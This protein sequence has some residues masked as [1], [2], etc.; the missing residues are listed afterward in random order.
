MKSTISVLKV[1]VFA[2]MLVGFACS[3]EQLDNLAVEQDLNDALDSLYAGDLAGAGNS[4][5]DALETTSE[6]PVGDH[7]R[8]AISTVQAGNTSAAIVEVQAAIDDL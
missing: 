1:V 8:A 4:L 7:I 2:V 3:C 5:N 6:G